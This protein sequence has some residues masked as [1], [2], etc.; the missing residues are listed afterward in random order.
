MPTF[1]I[2]GHWPIPYSSLPRRSS[3][4][5]S[6]SPRMP[7]WLFFSSYPWTLRI[8]QSWALKSLLLPPTLT[9]LEGCCSIQKHLTICWNSSF[10]LYTISALRWPHPSPSA[11]TPKSILRSCS[12]LCASVPQTKGF[13]GD[14]YLNP[15][16]KC[17]VSCLQI[18]FPTQVSSLPLRLHATI[19]FR[20]WGSSQGKGWR[21][22]E[23]KREKQG[24]SR[25]SL[26]AN[27]RRI[28]VMPTLKQRLKM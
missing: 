17:S 3:L 10:F 8:P 12:P 26:V 27:N 19:L 21:G 5:L 2:D 16:A 11:D 1:P 28:S 15:I 24:A 22:R 23:G 7:P 14:L 13:S 18:S 4:T 20:H 25:D 6:S 9:L